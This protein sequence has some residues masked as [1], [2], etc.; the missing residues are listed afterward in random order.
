MK[1][2]I[3]K[4][5][6]SDK[7]STEY[8]DQETGNTIK[9]TA[10]KAAWTWFVDTKCPVLKKNHRKV[11]NKYIEKGINQHDYKGGFNEAVSILEIL[12]K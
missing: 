6:A 9:L 4:R 12:I 3:L 5:T 10:G 2:I 8:T 11:L 7:D 1:K